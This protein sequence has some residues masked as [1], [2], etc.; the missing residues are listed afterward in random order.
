MGVLLNTEGN[1]SYTPG[2]YKIEECTITNKIGQAID[3]QPFLQEVKI[4]ESIYSPTLFCTISVRDDSNIL[5]T[6]PFYGIETIF[7]RMTRSPLSGSS[8]SIEKLFYATDYPLFGRTERQHVQVWS[9][10]GV[11]LHAWKNGMIKVSRSYG[12][13]PIS[14]EIVKIAQDTLGL[15]TMVKG[16]PFPKGRGIINIQSPLQAIEWLRRR[17]HEEDGSPFYFYQTLQNADNEVVLHSHKN[18]ASQ[19]PFEKYTSSKDYDKIPGTP[20]D[21][22]AR[23]RRILEVASE[24]K[25]GKFLPI[26]DGAYASKNFN[27]DIAN[28]TFGNTFYDY[29][30]KFPLGATINKTSVIEPPPSFNWSA[31]AEGADKAPTVKPNEETF[32]SEV[33]SKV[34]NNSINSESF[35]QSEEQNYTFWGKDKLSEMTA[36]PGI[37]DA[38]VHDVTI[39]GNFEFNAGKVIELTFPKA[40][41]PGLAGRGEIF[42]KNLSGK[43]ITVS[44]THIFRDSEYTINFKAKRDSFSK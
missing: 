11:C 30:G 23:K 43:Y 6:M 16:S 36:F 8:Q 12:P 31:P 40:L 5:E 24:L 7:I 38:L 18:M 25:F 1:V 34:S 3:V 44:A 32:E 39:F 37:F 33:F 20:E 29:A 27:V 26:P 42:D 19:G 4:T 28:R 14:D 13:G 41:D 35:Y 15:T 9:I 10:S 2:A 17:L 21:Y 22:D